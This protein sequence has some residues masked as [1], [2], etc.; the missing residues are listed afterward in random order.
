MVAESYGGGIRIYASSKDYVDYMPVLSKTGT[1][2]PTVSIADNC[3]A[4]ENGN[5]KVEIKVAGDTLTLTFYN[6]KQETLIKTVTA[7]YDF[8][9]LENGEYSLK[10]VFRVPESEK[11]FG[12]GQY[13]NGKFDL[14]HS[15]LPLY[16]ENRQVSVPYIISTK[17]YEFFR[18]NPAIG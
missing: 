3:G 1:E 4:L 18:H 11:L 12:M 5:T 6:G 2:N 16:Q 9:H 17:G 14:K 15:T 8:K 10:T 7:D 13:Q